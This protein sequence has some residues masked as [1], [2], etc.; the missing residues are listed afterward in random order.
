M[1]STEGL[2]FV[3]LLGGMLVEDLLGW[4]IKSLYMMMTSFSFLFPFL[5]PFPFI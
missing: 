5:S 1:D 3:G 2:A 4:D